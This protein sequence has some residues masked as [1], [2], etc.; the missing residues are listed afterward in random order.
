MYWVQERLG[1]RSTP[2]Q[3]LSRL[4]GITVKERVRTIE[5]LSAI[6]GQEIEMA[7]KYHVYAPGGIDDKFYAVEKTNVVFRNM[8]MFFGD[9]MPW[10]VDIMYAEGVGATPAF[11]VERPLSFTCCCFNRPFATMKDTEGSLLGSLHD[12]W[13]CCGGLDF[14]IRDPEGNRV[15]DLDGGCFQAGFWCPL[16]I[17]DMKNVRLVIRD[18]E[19]GLEV[20]QVT[21]KVPSAFKFFFAPDVDN[22]NVDFDGVQSPEHK[23]LIMAMT[24]FI[25]FRYFNDNSNDET[26]RRTV[27]NALHQRLLGGD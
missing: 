25:D 12:P 6:Y 19:T 4:D 1:I 24:I 10:S 27:F 14:T 22:Y 5:A 7:N 13:T 20:G 16:P 21:K 3:C 18:A 15:I 23:A 2:L 8:K 26:P 11:H 9:C 17:F